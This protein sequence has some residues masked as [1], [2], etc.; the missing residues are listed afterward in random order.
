M[1]RVTE[2]IIYPYFEKCL[3]EQEGEIKNIQGIF[4]EIHSW[5]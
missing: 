2:F 5:S 3:N 1:T 4:H